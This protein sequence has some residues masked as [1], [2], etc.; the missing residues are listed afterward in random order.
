[1]HCRRTHT[2]ADGARVLVRPVEPGDR[3]LLAELLDRLGDESRYRRFLAHRSAF[4]DRELDY[5]TDVDHLDHEAQLAIDVCPHAAL[6]G[7]PY[8]H[9]A[10]GTPELGVTVVDDWQGRGVGVCLLKV[11]VRR[12]R[13]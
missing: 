7:A 9:D 4:S 11:L 12:A 13:R 3:R 10:P 8:E 6:D 1:M 2:L 5:L